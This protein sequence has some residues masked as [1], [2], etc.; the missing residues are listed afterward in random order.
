M[1]DFKVVYA[2]QAERYDQMVR[3]EDYQGNIL[4]ALAEIRPLHSETVLDCGAGTGRLTRLLEPFAQHVV[5]LDVAPAMLS[6][7]RRTLPARVHYLLADNRQIP[8]KDAC[9][10]IVI[11]GWSLGHFV[12]WYSQHWRREI[13]RALAEMRRIVRPGGHFIIL[14]TLGTGQTKP[15]PPNAGLAAYYDW[16][17][18]NHHF[19]HTWIRT[20][21][22]FAAPAE[23]DFLTRFF[24][25][26]DLADWICR[27]K[28]TILPECTG[29]WWLTG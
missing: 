12:G 6:V 21:Y 25:G 17:E 20:D 13:G 26:D 8:I 22:R 15:Q 14:E 7:A 18:S 16:L 24:F 10:D 5:A 9:A 2:A 4:K 3:R 11:A 29:I 1:T 28:I 23:A 27:G 19:S